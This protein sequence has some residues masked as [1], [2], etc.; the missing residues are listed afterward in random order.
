MNHS[1]HCEELATRIQIADERYRAGLPTG[2]SN[3]EFDDLKESLRKTDPEHPLFKSPGGGSNLLS[4]GNESFEE[5]YY[6]LPSNT[7]LV[8]Q[9]KIDGVAIAL[10]YVDG[11]LVKAWNRKGADKTYCMRMIKNIPSCIATDGTV[12][13]RGELFG[14]H[15]SPES[16]QRLAAGH[17]RRKAPNGEGLIFCAFEIM[18]SKK[19]GRE[20]FHEYF[21]G[22]EEV[23]YLEEWGFLTPP[24]EALYEDVFMKVKDLFNKWEDSLLFAHFPTDGIVA[25]VT[26]RCLKENLGESS[27]APNWAIAIKQWKRVY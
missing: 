1:N 25:K 24:N 14:V 2:Y 16:S 10:R 6:K 20:V 5:W 23:F 11:L 15:R 22:H 19:E 7:P 4:L 12:E 18:R 3:E 13:I 17:L 26:D 8:V 21:E 9:P 27:V